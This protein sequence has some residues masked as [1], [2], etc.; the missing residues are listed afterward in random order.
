M[1][2]DIVQGYINELKKQPEPIV[3]SAP[4]VPSEAMTQLELQRLRRSYKGGLRW[5]RK[6]WALIAREYDART[7]RGD[8]RTDSCACWMP[9]TLSLRW[10]AGARWVGCARNG[11]GAECR[12]I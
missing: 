10:S 5:T 8:G 4:S 2:T 6:E 12:R 7:E 3:Q 1:R 11:R 9:K